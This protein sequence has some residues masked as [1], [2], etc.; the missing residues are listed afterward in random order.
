MPC[1]GFRAQ[2]I[3][4]LLRHSRKAS[5]LACASFPALHSTPIP[6]TTSASERY[7]DS[8]SG[9]SLDMDIDDPVA[10]VVRGSNKD[11]RGSVAEEGIAEAEGAQL[12]QVR[13]GVNG[14]SPNRGVQGA[15]ES[16]RGRG[17]S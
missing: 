14:F 4:R 11:S 15:W 9:G 2:V 17:A 7:R 13:P 12:L 5:R 6:P 1:F 8:R 16:F 3:P 10:K